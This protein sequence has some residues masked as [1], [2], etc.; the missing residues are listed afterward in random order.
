[1]SFAKIGYLFL[2]TLAKP[3]ANNV[4]NYAK[5]HPK[6]NQKCI[7]FAQ[8]VNRIEHRLRNAFLDK[9]V[10]LLRFRVLCVYIV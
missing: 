5:N 6:F 2:R 1:M 7:S 10:I 3:M 9:K 8:R 4:K